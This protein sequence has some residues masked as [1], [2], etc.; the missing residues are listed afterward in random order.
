MAWVAPDGSSDDG[1]ALLAPTST[2]KQN[3]FRSLRVGALDSVP[4]F[5]YRIVGTN[6]YVYYV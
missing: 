1:G 6:K 2:H 4:Y 5:Y 3:Y